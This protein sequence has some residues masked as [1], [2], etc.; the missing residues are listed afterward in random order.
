M[1]PRPSSPTQLSSSEIHHRTLSGH[2][3]DGIQEALKGS[4]KVRKVWYNDSSPY[5]SHEARTAA[6][7]A[8]GHTGAGIPLQPEHPQHPITAAQPD[9]DHPTS[10]Y[11]VPDC[12]ES[13]H[14][15]EEDLGYASMAQESLHSSVS[16]KGTPRLE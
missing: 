5:T 14:E 7:N 4:S 11:D 13:I 2:Y 16:G 12:P 1:P 9:S 10:N 3:F 15:E 8:E 6:I